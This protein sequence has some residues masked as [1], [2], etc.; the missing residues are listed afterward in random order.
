MGRDPY[1]SC[2]HPKLTQCCPLFGRGLR[3]P[4]AP[5]S[6]YSGCEFLY[7]EVDTFYLG[8]LKFLIKSFA[9]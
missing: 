2:P 4:P 8:P 7:A 5:V 3:G 6:L 1:L 9:L